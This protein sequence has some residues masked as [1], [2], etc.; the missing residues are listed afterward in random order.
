MV[1]EALRVAEGLSRH[2]IHAGVVDLYQ[3]KPVDPETLATAI[4]DVSDI[5]T[6]EEHSVVGR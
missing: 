3:L 2:D 4:G 6:L 5:V 1:H